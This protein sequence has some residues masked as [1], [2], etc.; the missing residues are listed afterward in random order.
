MGWVARYFISHK[1]CSGGALTFHCY[2]LSVTERKIFYSQNH[3]Q[4]KT[5]PLLSC[6]TLPAMLVL[7]AVHNLCHCSTVKLFQPIC[8]LFHSYTLFTLAYTF[9]H[10]D[11]YTLLHSFTFLHTLS[12]FWTLAHFCTFAHLHIFA[13]LH[14]F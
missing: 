12:H 14:T 9:A 8:T 4:L 6:S 2:F 11:I 10:L 13:H 3:V 7:P 1:V 5:V